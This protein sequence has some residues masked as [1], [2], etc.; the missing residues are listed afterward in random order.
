MLVTAPNKKVARRLVK[1][2]LQKRLAACVN[3]VP[4]IESHYWW[5]NK[6][7]SA[8]EVLMILKTTVIRLP[9]LQKCILENH[10]Y[11]TPEFVVL[12]VSSGNKKYLD[13]VAS[14]VQQH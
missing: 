12:P 11:E 14:S 5:K 6:I 2:I 9:Q 10:P 3:L 8:T 1:I 7:E 4:K 13:W